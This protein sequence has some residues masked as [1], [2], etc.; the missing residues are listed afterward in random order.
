MLLHAI[1]IQV[2]DLQPRYTSGCLTCSKAREQECLAYRA[3]NKK[4]VQDFFLYQ[5]ID[6]AIDHSTSK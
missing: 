1:K 3:M 4:K 5:V 2:A 6:P